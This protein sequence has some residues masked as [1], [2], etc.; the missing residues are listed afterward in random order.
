M[1]CVVAWCDVVRLVADDNDDDMVIEDRRKE[2]ES[3]V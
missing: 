1:R 2:G 3:V